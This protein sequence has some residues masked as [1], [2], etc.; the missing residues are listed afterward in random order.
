M[1]DLASVCLCALMLRNIVVVVVYTPNGCEIWYRPRL[2]LIPFL[3]TMLDW[4][5]A[6]VG[7]NSTDVDRMY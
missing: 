7:R 2:P 4:S 3:P 5:S 6:A 1:F